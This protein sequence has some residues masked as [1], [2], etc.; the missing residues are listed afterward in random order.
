[1]WSSVSTGIVASPLTGIQQ[2]SRSHEKIWSDQNTPFT[3]KR[4]STCDLPVVTT[5]SS[6]TQETFY[7]V[8]R[9]CPQY[10]E[11]MENQRWDITVP[12]DATGDKRG[13]VGKCSYGILRKFCYLQPFL[14]LKKTVVGSNQCFSKSNFM[15]ILSLLLTY[16]ICPV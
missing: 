1:L 13:D 8:R 2:H 5:Y 6:L 12:H 14:F 10:N 7:C 3:M 16:A 15:R 9:K 11:R 4:T